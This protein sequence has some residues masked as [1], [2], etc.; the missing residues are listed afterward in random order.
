MA[1]QFLYDG[2]FAG[3][4]GIGTETLSKKL[5]IFG[6]GAGNATVQIEGEGGADPYINFLANN[7]Q[8]WSLGIDDSDSDKFKLSEHSALGTNDYFVVDTSG[9]VG[10][11]TASPG[12]KLAVEGAIAV[13][14]AQNL[15]LRG[16][17]VGFENTALNNAA[18]IYNIGASGSSKLNIADSL[19]VIEAGNVG[20]GT[21]SPQSKLQ[22]AGGIQMADDTDTAVVGKV[23]TLRYR[24]SGNN[25]Y[26]DMCMQTAA[27]TYAW[28][29]IVQNNW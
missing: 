3:K 27:S 23:G 16:G 26:V 13:Q 1:L 22:V 11:G 17:R 6:T 14:D 8:H 29:N 10:I 18:Y 20:I 24:T 4:V 25:S 19:Y 9:N 5:T 7:A 28:I 21:V 2:Y 12:Y 15:W